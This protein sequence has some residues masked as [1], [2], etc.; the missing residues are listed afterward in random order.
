VLVLNQ[1]FLIDTA[2]HAAEADQTVAGAINR[3]VLLIIRCCLI[4]RTRPF[5]PTL[6]Y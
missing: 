6:Y 2:D 4:S 5:Q 1:R 3:Y